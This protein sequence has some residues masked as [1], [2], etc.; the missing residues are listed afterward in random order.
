M[1]DIINTTLYDYISFVLFLI[2]VII[3]LVIGRPLYYLDKIMKTRMV[4][5]LIHFFEYFAR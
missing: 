2:F 3:C 4:D 1:Q 5:H